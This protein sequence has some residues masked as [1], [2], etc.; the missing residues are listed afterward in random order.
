MIISASR[1]TDIPAFFPDWFFGRIAEGYAYVRNPYN[2]NQI[3]RVDLSPSVVDCIVFITKNPMRMLDR[4]DLLSRYHYYFQFTV[5]PY[6]KD[7]EPNVLPKDII[8]DFFKRLSLSIGRERVIWRYDPILL[9]DRYDLEFH[10]NAFSRMAKELSPYTERCVISF[11]DIYRNNVRNLSDINIIELSKSRMRETA[12]MISDVAGSYSLE[13]VSCAEEI[14][15]EDCGISHGKCIDEE[16]ITR[17]SGYGLSVKKDKTQRPHCCC[18]E[19]IDIG[20]YSTCLHGCLY[21]YANLDR[22]T[23]KRAL[24]LHDPQSPLIVG[25]IGPTDRITERKAASCFEHQERFAF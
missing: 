9:T 1:R 19:S 17:M 7:L 8:M 23:T 24:E 25:N 11:L 18:A 4:L 20:A 21:C 5:T 12:R 13:V 2:P 14:D 6:D 22:N 16:L 3:S 15:L 10:G